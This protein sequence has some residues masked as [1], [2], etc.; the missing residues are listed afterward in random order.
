MT[1]TFCKAR[2]DRVMGFET[3]AAQY[4]YLLNGWEAFSQNPE[5]YR[6]LVD[7]IKD[8]MRSAGYYI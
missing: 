4:R 8:Y 7:L 1:K 5:K 3:T 6:N 2:I